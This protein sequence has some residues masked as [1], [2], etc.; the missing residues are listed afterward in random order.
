MT[1]GMILCSS[2]PQK[3]ANEGTWRLV[4]EKKK[5]NVIQDMYLENTQMIQTIWSEIAG[6]MGDTCKTHSNGNY[7]IITMNKKPE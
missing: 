7:W 4:M 3:S 2:F 6:N 5:W 1:L